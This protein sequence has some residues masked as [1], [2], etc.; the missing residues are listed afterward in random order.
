[1]LKNYPNPF[2]NSTTVAFTLPDDNNVRIDVYDNSG[3]LVQTIYD[4][5]VT[6]NQEYKAEF[7][8]NMLRPGI[9]ICRMTTN[10]EVFTHKMMLMK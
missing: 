10:A 1:M 7:N 2:N 3:K 5:V 6:M 4:G 9:Y 8:G